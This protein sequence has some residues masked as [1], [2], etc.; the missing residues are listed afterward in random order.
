MKRKTLL[1]KISALL[2]CACLILGL[3]P[4]TT[5]ATEETIRISDID[6][7]NDFAKK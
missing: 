3:F 5:F 2:L 4:L 1:K 6:D 7:W